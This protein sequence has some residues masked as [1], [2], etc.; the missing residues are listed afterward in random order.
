MKLGQESTFTFYPKGG[1]SSEKKRDENYRE[2]ALVPGCLTTHF[3]RDSPAPRVVIT[4]CGLNS[5]RAEPASLGGVGS[6]SRVCLHFVE[7]VLLT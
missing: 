1:L 3:S 2:R 6:P 4:S 5:S 7:G